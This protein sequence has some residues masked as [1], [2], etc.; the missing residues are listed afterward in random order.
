MLL[1]VWGDGGESVRP[2]DRLMVY[3]VIVLGTT[4]AYHHFIVCWA[5]RGGR[6]YVQVFGMTSNDSDRKPIDGS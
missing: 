1:Y 4:L 6:V 2:Y 3:R 5:I